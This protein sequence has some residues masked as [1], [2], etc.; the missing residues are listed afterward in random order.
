MATQVAEINASLGLIDN[1]SPVLQNVTRAVKGVIETSKQAQ[2]ATG[3][4]IDTGAVASSNVALA[5]AEAEIKSMEEATGGLQNQHENYNKEVEKSEGFLAN[6]KGKV[7]GLIGAYAGMQTVKAFAGYANELASAHGRLKAIVDTEQEAL[8]LQRSVYASAQATRGQY[9]ETMDLMVKMRTQA[10]DVFTSNEEALKFAE[11]INKSFKS[12]GTSGAEAQGAIRQ[13]TQALA[14]GVLR[15]D[16]LNSVMENSPQLIGYIADYLNVP[17]GQ[18]RAM[19]ADGKLTADVIKQAM[20]A[21]SDEIDA[22]FRQ[23]PMTFADVG[24]GIKEAFL[25]GLHPAVQAVTNMLNSDAGQAFFQTL[26][27][28]AQMAGLTISGVVQVI[29]W[30][31]EGFMAIWPIISPIMM[32]LIGMMALY[33]AHIL[34]GAIATGVGAAATAVKAFAE[35]AHADGL[36]AAMAAQWGLNK[37]ILASPIFWIP[38]LIMAVIGVVALLIK[39]INHVKGTSFTV[40]GSIVGAIGVAIA[41]IQNGFINLV[42]GILAA[43]EIAYNGFIKF[44]NFIGKVFGPPLRAALRQFESFAQSVLSVLS[45]VA[46]RIDA[47][48]GSNLAA[49]VGGWSSSLSRSIDGMISDTYKQGQ[50]VHL[51]T[52]QKVDYRQRFQA[53]HDLANRVTEGIKGAMPKLTPEMPQMPQMSQMPQGATPVGA[54]PQ[55]GGAGKGSGGKKAKA[56]DDSKN[57]RKTADNTGRIKDKLDQGIKVK[58]EDLT[59]LR[60]LATSRSITTLSLDKVLVEVNNSFG[61]VHENVDLDGWQSSIE[62]GLMEAIH[63]TVEGGGLPA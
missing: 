7:A 34:A 47:V 29:S 49:V 28:G 48:F 2:M 11:L 58:N 26:I 38:A 12:F 1:I 31:G 55:E 21:A 36:M 19:A 24:N 46:S 10:G 4:M 14:S 6:M 51:Q 44:G 60:E 52:L 32:A 37:A 5:Q 63:T 45:N 9:G 25:F 41:V 59:Y 35:K 42:N 8:N 57:I 62:A 23:M 33:Q 17:R 22:S 54:M 20:F 56:R 13:L 3:T 61:D 39:W 27:Q 30:I 16:E 50:E 15:G 18:I 40:I 43:I 53:G